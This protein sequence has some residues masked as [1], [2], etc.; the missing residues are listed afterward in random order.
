[1][2]VELKTIRGTPRIVVAGTNKIAR[3]PKGT[4]V[5][6]GRDHCRERPRA[7]AER[8]VRHINDSAE[9]R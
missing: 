7:T 5:D 3:T 1:M 6:G 4:P 9:R 8:Q 2:P